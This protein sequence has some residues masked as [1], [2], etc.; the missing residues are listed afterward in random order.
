MRTVVKTAAAALAL[1]AVTSCLSGDS[2]GT[3][4]RP[5]E[6][7]LLLQ[8]NFSGTAVATVVVQVT[9]ADIASPLVF[10]I[11]VIQSQAVGTVTVPAGSSR[12]IALRAFDAGGVATHAGA[13]TVDVQP[14]TNAMITIVLQPLAG[15]VPITV[16]LGS[17]TITV[18]PARDTLFVGDTISFTATI[19]DASHNPVAAQV[20]WGTLAPALASIVTTGQQAGRVTAN[21]PGQTS[22]LATYGGTAGTATVIVAGWFASPTGSSSGDGSRRPWDLQTALNGGNGAVRPGDTIW[23]RGGTYAGTY[24][25][26]LAGTSTAPIVVRQY[27]G[28]RA[29][30]DGGT[31]S[32]ETFAVDG[33]WA[34]YWGFEV[35]Q[36]GTQRFCD[37][38]LGLRPTGVY[39]RSAHDVKLVNL[40]VHDVGHGVF[41]EDVTHNIELYGWIVYDGGSDNTTRSDG[42][43]MYIHNDGVG[44]KVLRDNVIFNQFGYGIHAFV[45]IGTATLKNIVFDGNALFNNGTVSGFDN[46][47]FQVGGFE[48]ADNDTLT[49]NMLYFSPGASGF[50]NGRVGFEMQMNGTALV[51]GNYMVGGGAVLDVGY[52]Q[53]LT[54]ADNT[55]VGTSTMVNVHDTSTAGWQW[56]GDQYWRDPTLTEWTFKNTDYTFANWKVASGLGAT[57]LVTAGQP[58][59]PQVFVR[60]NQ[61]EPGRAHV[62]IYNWSG[63]STVLVN[64]A[65]V[66]AIGAHYEVR[67]VQDVFGTPVVSGTYTGGSVSVPMSGVTP[68]A[69]IGGSPRSPIKTA[70][71]FDVFLVT[72]SG[73]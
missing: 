64:L 4:P 12:T 46:P 60:P 48:I 32:V 3:R 56:G 5:A 72:S 16:T 29:T 31:S 15:D 24:S 44:R 18:T 38:C 11:P 34:I 28:E 9:A 10:N 62:V 22:V 43:G 42:H 57:D 20:A 39:V 19:L 45:G 49:N 59:V 61:Y 68:P 54:V 2:T 55:L 8:A 73:P 36:S 30:I 52:W 50:V 27:R 71:N 7:K 69:P 14:G 1:L 70:P 66:V 6:A 17:F 47:N 13:V 51:R 35:M 23:V 40:V 67:N 25:T 21:H 63:Q 53:N 37:S 65:N 33:Q 26:A 41:T 58:A